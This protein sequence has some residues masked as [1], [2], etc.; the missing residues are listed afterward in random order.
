MHVLVVTLQ[1]YLTDRIEIRYSIEIY[2]GCV[3][4]R[5]DYASLV[6]ETVHSGLIFKFLV[7]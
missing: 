7:Y 2:T 3:C 5:F 6:N 4:E 1:I